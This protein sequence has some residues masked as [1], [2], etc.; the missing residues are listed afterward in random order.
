[1]TFRELTKEEFNIFTSTYKES[2]LYQS[3]Y[4]GE[5]M[6]REGYKDIYLGLSNG[7]AIIAATLVLVKTGST[8]KYGYIPK[9]LLI[10]YSDLSLLDYFTKE[11][12]KYLSKKDIVAVKLN[13]MIIKSIYDS[14]YNLISDNTDYGYLYDNLK[15]ASYSHLGFNKSFESLLPRYEAIIHLNKDKYKE[16]S[17]LSKK[18]RTKTRSAEKK[19]VRI[20][21]GNIDEIDYLYEK[22]NVKKHNLSWYKNLLDSFALKATIYYAKLDL[23][24][25]LE[26]CQSNYINQENVNNILNE[27]VI[28]KKGKSHAKLLDKKM[29]AD[30]KLGDYHRAL[31]DAIKLNASN[32][33]GIILGFAIV[34][35]YQGTITIIDSVY[36]KEYAY[37][38]ASHLLIWKLIDKY[39][40]LNYIDLNI[41]GMTS[42]EDNKFE[43]LNNFKLGFGSNVYE[44]MGDLE[45]VT[46]YPKYVMYRN[47][48]SLFK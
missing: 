32:P 42:K 1:M 30:I 43:G 4:Y 7:D 31:D 21:K 9:G 38:N 27:E 14:K 46:N 35:N 36:N 2:S 11:L 18:Y 10:D 33:D 13:P 22:L 6:S 39:S 40:E 5:F 47:S 20:Y 45:L 8:L 12:K 41:G 28:N 37:F 23:S 29:N 17:N 15:K 16:F 34:I 25:Y 26:L 44:Y 24:V 19:G 48:H 3:V